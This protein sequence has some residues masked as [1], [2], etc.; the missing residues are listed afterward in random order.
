MFTVEQNNRARLFISSFGVHIA[1]T[2]LLLVM[3]LGP[4]TA[5][6]R[7][8]PTPE[9]FRVTTRT[10]YTVTVAWNP[11]RPNSGNFNYYLSGAYG[12]TPAVLPNAATSHTFTLLHPSNQ[13]W[14]F[15][16]ARDAG[17]QASGQASVTTTTL[18]D[19]TTPTTP[20]VVSV[21]EVG[22]N[23]AGISWTAPQDDSPFFTYE[24]WVNGNV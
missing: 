18:L 9:H 11:A 19:T 23:Y 17:G 5:S 20:P 15:I 14:F 6:A 16:Y 1:A 10:A 24:I 22:S 21:N 7:R 2:A 12:V 8:P 4:S 13:Y 3:L